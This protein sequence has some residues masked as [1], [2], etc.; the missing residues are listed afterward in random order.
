[1]GDEEFVNKMIA[2]AAQNHQGARAGQS[3]QKI[4]NAQRRHASLPLLAYVQQHPN[5][6]NAAIQADFATGNYTMAQLAITLDCITQV[7]AKLTGRFE[8]RIL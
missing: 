1:M 8:A 7:L 4:S 6:R 5:N 3:S 2:M